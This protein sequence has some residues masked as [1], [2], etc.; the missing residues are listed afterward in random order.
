MPLQLRIVTPTGEV[1]NQT[2]DSISA[3]GLQGEFGIYSGHQ[4]FLTALRAGVA[5][6]ILVRDHFFLAHGEGFAEIFQGQIT[7]FVDTAEKP[8]DIDGKRAQAALERTEKSFKTFHGKTS[9][10][11]FLSLEQSRDRAKARIRAVELSKG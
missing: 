4:P 8:Q 11:E 9:S 10:T 1:L 2:V 3:R 5:H 6:Y 7:L